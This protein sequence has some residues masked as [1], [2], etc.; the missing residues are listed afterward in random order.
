MKGGPQGKGLLKVQPGINKLF[1]RYVMMKKQSGFTLIELVL[2]MAILGIL[3]AIAVPQF[4]D[5]SSEADVAAAKSTAGA[6]ASASAINF[7]ARMAGHAYT[8]LSATGS[9]TCDDVKGLLADGAW[10]SGYTASAT[11][12]TDVVGDPISCSVT[13]PNGDIENFTAIATP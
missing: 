7:A 6:A 11:A 2:V 9:N 12:F 10:P 3:A 13:S 8:V 1:W 4:I 5:L